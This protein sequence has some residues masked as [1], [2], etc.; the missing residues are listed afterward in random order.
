MTR[1]VRLEKTDLLILMAF[2][3]GVLLY[4]LLTSTLSGYG[5]FIDELYYISCSKRLAFGYVD[6][7][8]LSIL[9]LAMSRWILGD[10]L[11]A[12]RFLP[13]LALATSV[14]MT[15]MITHRLG[16]TRAAIVIAC[17]GTIAMPVYLVMGSFYSMNAFELVM[18]TILL[19][20]IIRLVQDGNPAYWLAIGVLMGLGM[21]TKHTMAV[22]GIVI[23]LGILLTPARRLVWNSWFAWGLLLCVLLL[24]PN[25]IWQ[26]LHGFPSLEFYRNAMINKNIPREP[27]GILSD[28]ALFSNPFAFPLWITGL[29]YFFVSKRIEPYRFLGWTYLALLLVMLLSQSSRP[30]RIGG[31]YPALF[32]GGAVA[33]QALSQR[34]TRRVATGAIIVMLITGLAIGAPLFTP[35]L[36][37]PATHNYIL[38][39]GVPLSVESGKT[40]DPLPQW[41]G[42][43]LGWRELA[44][45]VSRVYQSL[46]PEEQRKTVIV[47]TN[48]GVAGALELYG[49]EV[50]LPP[51]FATHN[52][53]HL[54]GPPPDSSGTYIAVSVDRGDLVRRF[55]RVDELGVQTCKYCTRPR[56]RIPIYVARGP[57]FSVAAEWP[58]LRI[59]N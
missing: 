50:D 38:A 45:E 20:L 3:L 53:Y 12:L 23:V 5:Y 59:Y 46:G 34:M 27:F 39:I 36:S 1:P 31:I 4:H 18:C 44:L 55:E 2:S 54:W 37:P 15:G 6:H 51:V 40:S 57:R 52:S 42:D 25:V 43:R 8:P 22:Y 33:I 30:D 35:L 47:S 41:L 29:V 13:A 21:E 7:P 49:T 14:F 10:S 48:Y 16:G 11:P 19:Y 28:Q 56:Q 17:L 26:Y 9:V 58:N 24:L 32:A